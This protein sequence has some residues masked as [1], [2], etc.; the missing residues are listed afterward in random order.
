M[1]NVT[2]L[3]EIKWNWVTLVSTGINL[4]SLVVFVG[5]GHSC[6]SLLY[7]YSDQL[8]HPTWVVIHLKT[9][10]AIKLLSVCI[11]CISRVHGLARRAIGSGYLCE[12]IIVRVHSLGYSREKKLRL[13]ARLGLSVRKKFYP[14]EQL[15]LSV[16]KILSSVPTARAI[17]SKQSRISNEPFATWSLGQESRNKPVKNVNNF[18]QA[19]C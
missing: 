3:R 16:Q 1:T 14:F 13:C 19:L 10:L 6:P 7:F 4:E 11:P 18:V 9:R 12:K 2:L 8:S 5:K 17:P 15:R